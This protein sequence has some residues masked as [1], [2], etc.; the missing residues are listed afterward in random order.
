MSFLRTTCIAAVFAG[1]I[2]GSAAHAIT[3][4]F[5]GSNLPDAQVRTFSSEGLG[6]T[7][8]AGK[9]SSSS[10]PSTINFAAR[11]VDQDPDGLGV[12]GSFDS[13]QIDGKF[14]NDVL[15]F[16]FSEAV[17][18]E[19]VKFGNVDSNDDFAFGTVVGSTFNRIEDFVDISNPFDL[20]TIATAA[21]R[22]GLGFGF[23]AIG[24]YD[25]FT[26]KNL[27]VSL[28]TPPGNEPPAVPLP[29]SGLML[30]GAVALA[31]GASARRRR[32]ADQV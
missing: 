15:V 12:D 19:T 1:S 23:G 14:G 32:K 17:V 27:T 5:T 21:Q 29:A 30:L 16:T 9:F 31:G 2:I 10:N 7:V 8:T 13:D 3:F 11:R 4:S 22:T 18:I 28:A 6:L 24:K 26:I 25:N 20:S